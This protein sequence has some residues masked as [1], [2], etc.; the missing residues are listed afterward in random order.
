[1]RSRPSK[2]LLLLIIVLTACGEGEVDDIDRPEWWELPYAR[3][4]IS[5]EPGEGA[6]YG[7]S[8]LPDIVLGPPTGRGTMSA[9]L[10]VL[11]LGGGGEIVLGFGGREIINGEGVDFLVFENP[12]WVQGEPE[13][14]FAELGEVSV[15][16]DGESWYTFPCEYSPDDPPPYQGCA[17]WSPTLAYDAFQEVPL[18][19]E[20]A[21]GDGFDLSQ[22][23]LDRARYVRIR[24]VWGLGDAPSQGFDLDA[25]GLIHFEEAL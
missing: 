10:D 1:M 20:R 22:V 8:L 6:G 4:V 24:D 17:G 5:F 9:S 25:V 3:E 21:G 13:Q 19:W 16:L 7:A 14:V 23:G 2:I 18:V 12:F 15:S 11:S